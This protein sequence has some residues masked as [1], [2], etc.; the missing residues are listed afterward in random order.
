MNNYY[1]MLRSN[2]VLKYVYRYLYNAHRKKTTGVVCINGRG[3]S[4][5]Y[6]KGFNIVRHS[7]SSPQG[8]LFYI[9][10]H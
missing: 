1:L 8:Y 7:L 6:D 9:K 10:Y 2:L 3:E 4:V 5:L